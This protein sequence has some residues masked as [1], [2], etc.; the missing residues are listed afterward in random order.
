MGTKQKL[1]T[2]VC[3]RGRLG[4]SRMELGILWSFYG[5][6][7]SYRGGW[8]ARYDHCRLLITERES[9]IR[10]Q[11]I[12]RMGQYW[13]LL[14]TYYWLLQKNSLVDRN[15]C[16]GKSSL[17]MEWSTRR[18]RQTH[19]NRFITFLIISVQLRTT[20]SVATI[21]PHNLHTN[22]Q[23]KTVHNRTAIGMFACPSEQGYLGLCGNKTNLVRFCLCVVNWQAAHNRCLMPGQRA[24][25]DYILLSKANRANRSH[26][27]SCAGRLD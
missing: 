2:V 6:W 26:F 22:G 12:V 10:M 1:W 9:V 24:P 7:G 3:V 13:L 19:R 4:A 11:S 23:S 20:N 17:G 5:T 21:G 18:R 25:S 27:S 8:Y 14:H 16:P 15:H